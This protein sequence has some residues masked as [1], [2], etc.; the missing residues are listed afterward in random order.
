MRTPLL[1]G[2]LAV[3]LAQLVIA[4]DPSTPPALGDTPDGGEHSPGTNAGR[5]QD[6][7]DS[8][9]RAKSDEML[10][11]AVHKSL[12]DDPSVNA[13][14]IRVA[15]HEGVVQLD[16][17]VASDT[18][19]DAAKKIAQQVAGVRRVEN[20]L[21]VPNPLPPGSTPIPERMGH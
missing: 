6:R 7:F 8:E 21:N 19:R 9:S 3:A 5:A 16:G 1:A 10:A 11:S 14:R 2:L 13:A 18:E 15:A 4:R 12:S 20:R 17:D